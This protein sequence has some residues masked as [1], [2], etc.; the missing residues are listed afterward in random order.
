[1][2]KEAKGAK[3]GPYKSL[4][5]LSP[6]QRLRRLKQLAAEA[7]A[8][9]ENVKVGLKIGGQGTSQFK[10]EYKESEEGDYVGVGVRPKMSSAE[11]EELTGK[12]QQMFEQ[13]K[14]SMNF[15]GE[16]SR[17][18]PDAPRKGAIKKRRKFL[19]DKLEGMVNIHDLGR[20]GVYVGAK[21]FVDFVLKHIG[22]T[23]ADVRRILLYA[24]GRSIDRKHATIGWFV[25][26]ELYDSCKK[27]YLLE[28][29]CCGIFPLKE[30]NAIIKQHCGDM[31]AEWEALK[32][33][34]YPIEWT[35]DLKMA[36]SSCAASSV[37]STTTPTA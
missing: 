28:C 6:R 29:H 30:D 10:V 12:V 22:A 31:L 3:R 7:E 34:G 35:S 18:L 24:D 26:I 2:A 8:A 37:T 13:H 20:D 5:D 32:K 21:S 23:L 11:S 14:A 9:I 15:W 16:I 17:L 4:C 1:M 25:S 36:K 19:T 33:G 27:P